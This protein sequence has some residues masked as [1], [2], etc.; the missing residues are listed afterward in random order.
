MR[1]LI[2]AALLAIGSVPVL[3]SVPAEASPCNGIGSSPVFCN[4]CHI[5]QSEVTVNM[6]CDAPGPQ[7]PPGGVPIAPPARQGGNQ[8]CNSLL[9]NAGGNNVDGLYAQ[10]CRDAVVAGQTPC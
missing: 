9:I 5:T 2:M 4:D 1:A 3:V 8:H 7:G 6:N 10:C